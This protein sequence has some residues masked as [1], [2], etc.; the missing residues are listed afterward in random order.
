M[1]TSALYAT[2]LNSAVYFVIVD[3]FFGAFASTEGFI[4]MNKKELKRMAQRD[5]AREKRRKKRRRIVFIEKISVAAVCL[6]LIAGAGVLIYHLLP[7]I[8]VARQ[9]EEANAYIETADYDD[10]IASCQEAL[11][12]D[13]SSIQAYRAMAGA[14]LTKED[15]TS[16]EQI[17][18]QGWET[19]QDESLLQY[20]CT[21]LLN[22]AVADI[23][24]NNCT[25]GTLDKCVSALEKNPENADAYT[26]LDACYERLF[27]A[28]ASWQG[29]LCDIEYGED[30]GYEDYQNVM[31]R[32]LLVYESA[33]SEKLKAEILKFAVPGSDTIWMDVE[34]LQDYRN[35]LSRIM[36]AG[37]ND[38]VK[39]LA[40]CTDKA[41]AMQDFFEEAF[42]I[43]E[44]G[45]FDPIKEFMN[46]EEYISIRDEFMNGTMEYWSGATY[47]P[48]SREKMKF[49][50]EDGTWK[51]AFADYEECENSSDVIN[52]WSAKQED[53][54]VQRVCISYEPAAENGEYFPHTIYEFI[55]LYSNVEING[56][57]VPQMN[58]RFETRVENHEGTTTQLIGDWGG[59]HEWT[60]EF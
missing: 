40:A 7:G 2:I 15:A 33:P 48:V 39:E 60:T 12:I 34:H 49:V 54:G 32:L 14:Y 52:I 19:T 45:D 29:L 6:G 35:L 31:L 1:S 26:L 17:L 13:S 16:A 57:Y 50:N 24:G 36:Q 55:Y 27:T 3:M 22:E 46:Q 21:V 47:I 11:K 44:S 59:P 4:V 18:Y 25:L 28:D 42:A 10:A 8:Q 43:F 37:E 9:L 58:Y 56:E 5:E 23:N 20:Y 38:A 53:A 51:F 41:I 30:C